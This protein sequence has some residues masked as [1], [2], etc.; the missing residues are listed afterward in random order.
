[1]GVTISDF[2]LV[3]VFWP[4]E[5]EI[6]YIYRRVVF[7]A[8]HELTLHVHCCHLLYIYCIVN[9]DCYRSCL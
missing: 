9:C 8:N 1:M 4:G 2:Y 7:T 6:M 3:L 5:L